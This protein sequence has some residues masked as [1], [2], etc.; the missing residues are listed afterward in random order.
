MNLLNKYCLTIIFSVTVFSVAAQ[1][2]KYAGSLQKL[3]GHTYTNEKKIA[4]FS[5]YQ[6]RQGDV[7]SDLADANTMT[8]DL[9]VKKNA[10]AI[11][12]S[13]LTDTVSRTYTIVDVIEVK[14]IPTGWE[15]RSADCQQGQAEGEIL[16]ALVKTQNKA[17][18]TIVKK[19]WRCNRDKLR[20][21]AIQPKGIKCINEGF[22][23]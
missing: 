2:G 23:E 22:G 10:A 11:I 3:I 15:V 12:Y 7:I 9:F 17:Y 18:M 14:N 16:I 1:S 8:L 13:Q 19:A 4:G 20:F 6:Y 21:E 5:T